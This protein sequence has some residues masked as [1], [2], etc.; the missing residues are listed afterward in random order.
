MTRRVRRRRRASTPPAPPT[1]AARGSG[2]VDAI[3]GLDARSASSAPLVVEARCR[4]PGQPPA[5]SYEGEGY[6]ILRHPETAVVGDALQRVVELV[7]VE[8]Q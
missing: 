8:L 5:G 4:E 6:V 7:R 2:R 3:H 1:C